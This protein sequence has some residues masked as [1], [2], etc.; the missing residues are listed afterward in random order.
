M[1]AEGSKFVLISFQRLYDEGVYGL[2]SNLGSLFVRLILQPFEES[3]F[4]LF[5]RSHFL[6]QL[7]LTL[8]LRSSGTKEDLKKQAKLLKTLIH[9]VSLLGTLAL[10]FGP[11]STSLFLRVL[12]SHKW[13]ETEA[14]SVLAWYCPYIALMA[15]NGSSNP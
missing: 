2:V 9:C 11:P 1:L 8:L 3:A 15:I 12:Y 13:S 14:D 10:I 7:N 6:T 4:T 5:S